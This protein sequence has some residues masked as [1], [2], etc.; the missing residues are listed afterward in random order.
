MLFLFLINQNHSLN[1]LE[2]FNLRSKPR[3]DMNKFLIVG[4]GNVG[5]EYSG[6]RHNIG[7]EILDYACKEFDK[8]FLTEKLGNVVK[9]KLKGKSLVLLKPSTF[10]NLSGKSVRYWLNKENIP[11]ENLLVI[12]D[13]LNLD[14]GSI[15]IRTK[16]SDGGHN[17]LKN[18]Q[19][20][21]NTT[22]YNR[23]RFG[24]GGNFAKGSQSD[25]VLSKWS[26]EEKSQLITLKPTLRQIIE[27]YV[28]SGINATMNKFNSK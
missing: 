3:I 26:K 2:F 15:R 6:T 4:I 24:I 28:Y 20:T 27:Y 16:G 5:K 12:S 13:D 9:F 1:W 11:L 25:F 19:E 22:N 8:P 17:G 14:F 10:V 23:L 7:F 18:I 21:L